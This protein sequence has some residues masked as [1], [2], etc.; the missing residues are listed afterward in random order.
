MY[1]GKARR[2]PSK[3]AQWTAAESERVRGELAAFLEADILQGIFE[4]WMTSTL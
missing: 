2:K 4:R 3:R 1:E